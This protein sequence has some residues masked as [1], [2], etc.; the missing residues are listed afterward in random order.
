M[1]NEGFHLSPA[2][3]HAASVSSSIALCGVVT[4]DVWGS[5]CLAGHRVNMCAH[6]LT[7]QNLKTLQRRRPHH[8]Y[9]Y[10]EHRLPS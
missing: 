1:A 7:D 9:H 5:T 6:L 10:Y 3:F 4:M 2:N 8:H